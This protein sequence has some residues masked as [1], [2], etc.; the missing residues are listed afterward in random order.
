MSKPIYDFKYVTNSADAEPEALINSTYWYDTGTTENSE[1]VYYD[2]SDTYAYWYDSADWFISLVA[3]VGGTPTNYFIEAVTGTLTG[4]GDFSGTI[5]I[6]SNVISDAW[7]RAE[8]TAF[9]SLAAFVGATEGRECFRGFLPVQGDSTDDL[10]VNVW[11][12]TSGGSSAFEMDRLYG[13]DANWCSMRTDARLESTWEEREDAMKFAG[14]V[15]A[16]LKSTNNLNEVGNVTW[17][18]ML[19]LPA[20]PEIYRTDGKKN[21]ARYW[22]QTVELEIVYKTEST[23]N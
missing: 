7:Y 5:T 18:T 13:A 2:T 20:E 17:C 22:R 11:Q 6:K 21:R 10:F 19:D 8:T 1:A 16:W 14:A 3:D 9:E 4:T 12:L 23:Y 15:E